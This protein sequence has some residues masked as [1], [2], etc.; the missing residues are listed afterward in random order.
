VVVRF[1]RHPA[2]GIGR[3]AAGE[4]V[5]RFFDIP[6]CEEIALPVLDEV[7]D[8]ELERRQRVWIQDVDGWMTGYV[9]SLNSAGDAYLVDLP[10]RQ[11]EYIS[12]DRL[13]VRWSVP[14]ADPGELL[15]AGTTDAKRFHDGRS[16]FLR[17][18]MRQRAA[19]Q[20]L[21]GVWSSAV[22]LHAHQVGAARRVLADPVK[23]YLLADE[24]GLG[25]TIEAGMVLRQL[26]IDDHGEVLVLVPDGLVTQ[27]RDE[28][29]S[30]F[31][32]G[33]F[34]G[35][36]TVVAHSSIAAASTD[37]RLLVVVD[38]AHR[39]TSTDADQNDYAALRAISGSTKC[40]LLLSATPVRSNEDGFL[41]ML[42][43][44]DPTTYP[45]DEIDAFRRRVEIRDDLAEALTAM[46]EDTPVRFL[47]D[48]ARK[49]RQLLPDEDWLATDLD[50]LEAAIDVRDADAARAL[51]DAIRARLGE[52][53]RIHRRLI[54][55]R[56]SASLAKL[57]PVRG[58][59][60]GKNWLLADPDNR[61]SAIAELL[62]DLLVEFPSMDLADHKAAAKALIGRASAPFTALA[63]LATALRAESG[64]DLDDPEVDALEGL[65]GTSTG[66]A[67]AARIDDVLRHDTD[68]DRLDAMV[69][70]A[71]PQVGAHRVAVASSFP[72]TAAA[73]A[74]RLEQQFGA[75]RVVRLLSTMSASERA[76]AGRQFLEDSS[77]SIIVIDRGSEEGV[78]LQVVEEVLHL[79]LPMATARLEQRL[80]RF[81]RWTRRGELVT[82]PVR[83]T[84]FC[85][86]EDHVDAQ[87]GAWRQVLDDAIDIFGQSSATL[88]YVLPAL[89]QEF[90]DL[91]LDVGL[92][93]AA[94][95]LVGRRADLDAHRRRIEGQDLLDTIEE[96]ADDQEWAASMRST[97]GAPR[98]LSRFRGYVVKTLGLT[99]SVG[100]HGTRYGI[101]TKHPPRLTESQVASIGTDNL[102]RHYTDR[103][104]ASVNEI[105]LLR[106]GEPIVDRFTELTQTDERG[107]AF[108]LEVLQPR[109]EPD[110]LVVFYM[111]TAIIGPDLGRLD[112]L[113]DLYPGT[114]IAARTQ[115]GRH[116]APLIETVWWH[117]TRGEP[118][119]RIRDWLTKASGHN[120]G[121]DPQR[122][123]H[124]AAR[125][126][127]AKQVDAAAEAALRAVAERP[128]ILLATSDAVTKFDAARR[129][130]RAMLS[131]RP[132]SDADIQVHEAVHEAVAYAIRTS[133]MTIDAC[134]AVFI[135]GP[136]HEH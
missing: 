107:R 136:D 21:A 54:R 39:L 50:R 13:R 88:Q 2:Y 105:G 57:F 62:A 49:L 67:V 100:P 52:T 114:G 80:G 22:E 91:A 3:V 92:P 72:H 87:L 44:L 134:G 1:V 61:R 116:F 81:D 112:E 66:R 7:R 51:A 35:R 10:Q 78:N 90:I 46:G 43:L 110:S 71:W 133:R 73:A 135:T 47:R 93:T 65:L 25:K 127:V 111:F 101:S 106:W 94:A 126:G 32:V 58:R 64:H 96:Q 84:V 97:D 29:N 41:R 70:W 24:V 115:V 99:E 102:R 56:R 82:P 76:E 98:I 83:S 86:A 53:H 59:T 119:D 27:W 34:P 26:L 4:Y 131:T 5:V 11:A 120:L 79:D 128:Q 20:G 15:K 132:R 124:L 55:T 14:V 123:R 63:D 33:Q 60:A 37:S 30:K 109:S 74:D 129:R 17:D 104:L 108:A 31:R 12:A 75:A 48:P 40:L 16:G 117:P 68:A 28:L 6:G 103:R 121:A 36:V 89:E 19:A 122:F 77:R 125:A 18:V 8:I 23:R 42:H 95:Q 118:D 69:A 113:D 9:D 38:E 85:E 45:L 130:E